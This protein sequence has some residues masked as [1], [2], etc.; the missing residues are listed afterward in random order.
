ML[1]T[2][3]GKSR[4]IGPSGFLFWTTR[5]S[6]FQNR[7]SEGAKRRD[8]KISIHLRH[9]KGV[10]SIK[11]P[12]WKKSKPKAEI[13]KIRLSSLGYRSIQFF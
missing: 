3:F 1:M 2:K 5:F 13:T 6:Q 7:N 12:R 10:R 11:E 8:L 4:K 9:E